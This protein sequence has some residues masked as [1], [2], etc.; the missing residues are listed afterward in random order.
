[1]EVAPTPGFID[2]LNEKILNS[3]EFELNFENKNYFLKIKSSK[4]SLYLEI[5]EEN[6]I[7]Y[8]YEVKF[9]LEELIQLDKI[10]KTCD[11]MDDAHELM[12][13][14]IKSD[15][16]AIKSISELKLILLINI[17]QANRSVIE[18]EIRL[19]KKFNKTEL[20]IEK[21]SKEI[22]ELR[23][24]QKKLEKEISELKKENESLKEQNSIKE[25]NELKEKINYY[26]DQSI[27]K[28]DII[29]D[30]SNFEF[31]KERLIKAKVNKKQNHK[32]FFELL[33]KAKRHGDK[34]KD[35]HLRCDMYRNTLTII[36]T[37]D[38][39]IFG[40]FT[41]QTWEGNDFDKEDENAFCFSLDKHKIYNSIKGKKA[42]FASPNEGPCFQ[43]CIFEV[44]DNCFENGGTCDSDVKSHFDNIENDYEINGGKN[45][46]LVEDL[47]VFAVYFE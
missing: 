1:M 40:G 25:L 22:N 33:Y 14:N 35:F 11:N 2:G 28:S 27:I 36:K 42:I 29:Q 47:E 37:T 13:S 30:Q 21:L 38:G 4:E 6:N 18:K 43:N 39:L 24:S 46:F 32:L 26:F 10:F 7:I 16:T 34:A 3:S 31:I 12:V 20:V 9:N 45:N 8:F 23:I 5:I 19:T 17:L 15:K 44:K 41:S